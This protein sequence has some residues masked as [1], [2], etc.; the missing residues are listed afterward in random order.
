MN[1]QPA[2]LPWWARQLLAVLWKINGGKPV[3]EKCTK[4]TLRDYL[5]EWF[6]NTPDWIYWPVVWGLRMHY[7][8]RRFRGVIGALGEGLRKRTC[9]NLYL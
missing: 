3:L 9:P 8:W 6:W 5:L 2:N 7:R 1:A 4:E